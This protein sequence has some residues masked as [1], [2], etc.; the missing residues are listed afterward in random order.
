MAG[1]IPASAGAR[2]IP[3][4]IRVAACRALHLAAA[5]AV[6]AEQSSR[7]QPRTS[8]V[9]TRAYSSPHFLTTLA[10][11]RA[12]PSNKTRLRKTLSP[13]PRPLNVCS[14]PR[15]ACNGTASAHDRIR[16]SGTHWG[17]PALL[18]HSGPGSCWVPH[19]LRGTP[20][21]SHRPSACICAIDCTGT[22]GRKQSQH[23][24]LKQAR[25]A[26]RVPVR[27][28]EVVRAAH[29]SSSA[30][31]CNA[32]PL[33]R[34]PADGACHCTQASGHDSMPPGRQAGMPTRPQT[35]SSC[36]K[37]RRCT[38][39]R[40]CAALLPPLTEEHLPGSQPVEEPW[41]S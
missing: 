7:S 13:F 39:A 34:L 14:R 29:S 6:A 33:H 5:N 41:E 15:V 10:R 31:A 40:L 24:P 8:R 32:R 19:L 38:S 23:T 21:L 18:Y 3:N 27:G 1:L 30:Y 17:A 25:R 26:L 4:V 16:E 9:Q 35:C 22:G 12:L 36:A 11:P 20:V 37:R 28:K 2:R